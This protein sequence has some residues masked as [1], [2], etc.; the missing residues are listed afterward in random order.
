MEFVQIMFNG[1]RHMLWY[2]LM[3][4][5]GIYQCILDMKSIILVEIILSIDFFSYGV[6]VLIFNWSK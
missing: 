4:V 3:H 2:Y 1:M 6:E 5:I